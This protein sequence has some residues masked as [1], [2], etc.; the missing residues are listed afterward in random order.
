MF[1]DGGR[2]PQHQLLPA[3]PAG[4]VAPAPS[5]APGAAA[6]SSSRRQKELVG[7]AAG[8]WRFPALHPAMTGDGRKSDKCVFIHLVRTFSV[9]GFAE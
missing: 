2:P 4:G 1:T 8:K 9:D 7:G 3:P 6:I 5:D